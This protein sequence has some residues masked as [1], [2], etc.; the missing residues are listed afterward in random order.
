MQG[1]DRQKH[2]PHESRSVG[3]K[4]LLSGLEK[5]TNRFAGGSTPSENSGGRRAK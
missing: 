2:Q 1:Q 3:M 5:M 4:R